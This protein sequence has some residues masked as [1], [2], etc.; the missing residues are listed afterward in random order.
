MEEA[1]VEFMA[2]FTY[3]KDYY[4][5]SSDDIFTA[6]GLAEKRKYSKITMSQIFE[7]LNLQGDNHGTISE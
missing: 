1:E 4:T 7:K 6:S 2:H 3:L 5:K